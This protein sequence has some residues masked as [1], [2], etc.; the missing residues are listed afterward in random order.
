MRADIGC[1]VTIG[2]LLESGEENI[3]VW[4]LDDSLRYVPQVMTHVISTGRK[5]VFRMKTASGRVI[6]AT[7]NHP[8]LSYDGWSDLADLQPGHRIATARHVP[9]PEVEFDLWSDDMITVLAHLIGDGSMLP[10]QPL[11]YATKD[12]ANLAVVRWAATR[13]FDVRASVD[14]YPS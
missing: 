1:E 10:R 9:A 3:L 7:G 6:E 4:S 14:D 13:A 5:E 8:F 2:Q 12:P 11:R